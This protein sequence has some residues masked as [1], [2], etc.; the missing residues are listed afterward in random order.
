MKENSTP[1]GWC[2]S[3]D[4]VVKCSLEI[5]FA[6]VFLA[7][8][9]FP[10]KAMKCKQERK[11]LW[12]KKLFFYFSSKSRIFQDAFTIENHLLSSPW[13]SSKGSN[14]FRWIHGKCKNKQIVFLF[15]PH[16]HAKPSGVIFGDCGGS[17]Y[18]VWIWVGSLKQG[19]IG[20]N[21]VWNKQF[22][23][24]CGWLLVMNLNQWKENVFFLLDCY[25]V[26]ENANRIAT[27]FSSQWSEKNAE[28]GYAC[29]YLTFGWAT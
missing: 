2:I 20:L 9:P 23:C 26:I 15:P 10:G 13:Y 6:S 4:A 17:G 1:V 22:T 18:T 27:K 25:A 28:W 21:W 19:K 14:L 29:L 7:F 3:V 11:P 8:S 24:Y 5:F 16:S 12:K